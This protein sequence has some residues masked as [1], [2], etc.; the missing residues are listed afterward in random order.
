MSFTQEKKAN[1]GICEGCRM[2][3]ELG[4]EANSDLTSFRPVIGGQII[5]VYYNKNGIQTNARKSIM[6]PELCECETIDEIKNVM[7][8]LAHEI[9][10]CCDKYKKTR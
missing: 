1:V 2:R 5:D 6:G 9:A 8:N 7:M 10:K 4:M 3:C